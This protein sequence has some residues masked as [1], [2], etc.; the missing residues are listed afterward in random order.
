[1]KKDLKETLVCEP[2]ASES[3]VRRMLQLPDS[4]SKYIYRGR[5]SL[6]LSEFQ[7]TEYV[8]K[9]FVSKPFQKLVYALRSSKAKR[10]W[11]HARILQSRGF[12][13]PAPLAYCE[14]RSK[15]GLLE[16]SFYICRFED[17]VPLKDFL[18]GGDLNHLEAFARFAASLH[19]A[20]ILH[21]DLNNTNV[22]VVE[23][24]GK[25]EFSLIDLNR[26]RV[27]P[28]GKST[29]P[30]ESARDLTRFC[31]IEDNFEF[32]AGR[33]TAFRCWPQ[34]TLEIIMQAKRSHDR[35]LRRKRALKSF[36]KNKN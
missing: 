14:R 20:G 9:R 35:R 26:M 12:L 21:G 25:P 18:S 6:Y 23:R 8:V 16:E 13:T 32:F 33:Y 19:Q 27:L 36:L 4:A 7:Q 3:E 28:A 31:E 1:M 15:G 29:G 10:S 2:Y 5:N 17:S 11:L 24:N 22:R 34:E 30:G